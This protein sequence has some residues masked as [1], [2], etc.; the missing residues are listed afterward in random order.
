LSDVNESASLREAAAFVKDRDRFLIST[1]VN[2]DGDG[3]GA[4]MAL[5]WAAL[6]LG[7]QAEIVIDSKP[8][9]TFEFFTD[10]EWIRQ[11]G[12]DRGDGKVFV[13][14]SGGRAQHRKA[15]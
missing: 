14:H 10:Y 3:I 5:K 15:G 8:P 12:A 7:K 6:A 13:G 1:H 4:V 9:E 2:P 11:S